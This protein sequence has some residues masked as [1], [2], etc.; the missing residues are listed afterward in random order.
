MEPKPQ[1]WRRVYRDKALII[2]TEQGGIWEIEGAG[3]RS[4]S[5]PGRSVEWMQRRA[6]EI[7]RDV[8]NSEWTRI[9]RICE[10]PMRQRVETWVCPNLHEEAIDGA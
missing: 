5:G 10:G 8:P 1:K 6:D 3:V 4:S 9:C 2:T 7:A